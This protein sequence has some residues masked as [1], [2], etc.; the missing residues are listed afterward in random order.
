MMDAN[1]KVTQKRD[2]YNK[3]EYMA[4]GTGPN[5][6]LPT[7]PLQA[8]TNA[9]GGT[10]GTIAGPVGWIGENLASPL[11]GAERI[12]GAAKNM[13][14]APVRFSED[15]IYNT[16]SGG[17]G[18]LE[19]EKRA[20]E[21]AKRGSDQALKDYRAGKI[22][23]NTLATRLKAFSGTNEGLKQYESNIASGKKVA[24][25]VIDTLSLIPVGGALTSSLKGINKARIAAKTTGLF[26][27]AAKGPQSGLIGKI[28]NKAPGLAKGM[29]KTGGVLTAIGR[30]GAGKLVGSIETG[31]I[32]TGATIELAKLA[33][34][35][36]DSN[37]SKSEQLKFIKDGKLRTAID[38]ATSMQAAIPFVSSTFNKIGS[39]KY[40]IAIDSINTETKA[41]VANYFAGVKGID[42]KIKV[43]GGG[44]TTARELVTNDYIRFCKE[45]LRKDVTH[46]VPED[47]DRFTAEMI[48]DGKW[49]AGDAE[50]NI[51][52]AITAA[53]LGPNK[54]LGRTTDELKTA[55]NK[56][57]SH[58]A[59]TKEQLAL[60]APKTEGYM[61][62]GTTTERGY[63]PGKVKYKQG[64]PA[65]TMT[66]SPVKGGV[67]KGSKT[68]MGPAEKIPVSQKI[69]PTSKVTEN[70]I[71]LGENP[72]QYGNANKLELIKKEPE[73]LTSTPQR[74]LDKGRRL[75]VGAS[76]DPLEGLPKVELNA[77]EK[78]VSN[79]VVEL[80]KT[81]MGKFF[82]T[83]VENGSLMR[84]IEGKTVEK[85][86]SVTGGK[87]N[88]LYASL[89][90]V[91]DRVE[92]KYIPV[93]NVKNLRQKYV[94]M[95]LQEA[96]MPPSMAKQVMQAMSEANYEGLKMNG[97]V[98]MK[99]KLAT[100]SPKFNQLDRAY[101]SARFGLRPFF[102]LMQ[103]TESTV[104]GGIMKG[105]LVNSASKRN[106]AGIMAT[107]E[108]GKGSKT[109]KADMKISGTNEVLEKTAATSEK[110]KRAKAQALHFTDSFADSLMS[111]PYGK[112]FK[113]VDE[114]PA[115]KE[116]VKGL[117][118]STDKVSYIQDYIKENSYQGAKNFAE[119]GM[120]SDGDVALKMSVPKA[121]TSAAKKGEPMYLYNTSRS[122]FERG[123]HQIMFPASYTKKIVTEGSKWLTK[124]SGSRV[125]ITNEGLK[126]YSGLRDRIENAAVDHPQLR[127]VIALMNVFDPLSTDFPLSIGG[128]TPF[129][130]TIEKMATNPGKYNLKTV[131]GT[132][133][134]VKQLA[135]NIKEY[136]RYVGFGYNAVGKEE[137]KYAQSFYPQYL[138]E[139]RKTAKGKIFNQE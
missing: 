79:A 69:I 50:Q 126:Q 20:S 14:L 109:V 41:K 107:P 116:Y 111:T 12:A 129:Y 21:L 74:I 31:L 6:T 93:G 2:T 30:T 28:A 18:I 43:Q 124:G 32:K 131:K 38:I 87:G 23:K 61:V 123:L 114:I 40:K 106:Y 76:V 26:K 112:K 59:T 73:V 122:P 3:S 120:V 83:K 77:I 64:T 98:S 70:T 115:F 103:T 95:A 36:V 104:Y 5:S 105:D 65:F 58:L 88:K 82:M 121:A 37:L 34:R 57:L 118:E 91:L 137:P 94:E 90:R 45:T 71:K 127:P 96:K 47:W 80:R 35:P 22:D 17:K 29:S 92:N 48:K 55:M 68:I 84:D 67:D 110:I 4:M 128:A 132:N 135:P 134:V 27:V 66:E 46:I 119:Q 24:G 25:D 85:L 11:T 10:L 113:S 138:E 9:I 101:M 117:D 62:G 139:N 33:G 15:I 13:A 72:V 53:V 108:Y 52:H 100:I 7:G 102:W 125:L 44:T 49:K 78:K 81:S 51:T 56:Q 8:I 97:I 133:E 1:N 75:Q 39:T 60:P 63:K 16:M 42:N 136:E 19:S 86:D 89:N 54:K 130:R 99:S